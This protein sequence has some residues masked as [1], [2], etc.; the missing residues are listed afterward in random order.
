MKGYS[1]VQKSARNNMRFNNML[2]VI[3]TFNYS[4]SEAINSKVHML[5]STKNPSFAHV[6]KRILTG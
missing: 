2:W 4:N 1:S 3:E 5:A 6:W